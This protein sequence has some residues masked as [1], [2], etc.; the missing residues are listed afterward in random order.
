MLRKLRKGE[1]AQVVW[2]EAIPISVWALLQDCLR[3]EPQAR[4]TAER[5]L[6]GFEALQLV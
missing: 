2:P 1:L 3:V 5:L 4:S 6:A